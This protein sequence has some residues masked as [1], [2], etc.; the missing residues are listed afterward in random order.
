MR[1]I[2]L[3]LAFLSLGSCGDQDGPVELCRI[4]SDPKAFNGQVVRVVDTVV[5]DGH[6]DPFFVPDI[7]CPALASMPIAFHELEPETR[8]QFTQLIR[9]LATTSVNGHPAGLKGNYRLRILQGSYGVVD[10]SLI[11]ASDLRIA[12]A[13]SKANSLGKLTPAPPT[14]ATR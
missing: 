5:V 8:S 9:S 6:A 11:E 12:D 2:V 13:Q 10:L 1:T 3:G 4:A 7:E 14:N